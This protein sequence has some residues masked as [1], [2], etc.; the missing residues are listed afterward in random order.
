MKPERLQE[1]EEHIRSRGWLPMEESKQLLA[2]LREAQAELSMAEQSVSQLKEDLKLR[3]ATGSK[4]AF[5]LQEAQERAETAE[6]A[7]FRRGVEAAKE[8]AIDA[9]QGAMM[10]LG[11]PDRVYLNQWGSAAI[12]EIEKDLDAL[13]PLTPTPETVQETES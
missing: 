11:R 10:D 7:G 2:A 1:I 8:A 6:A 12:R 13:L 4:C 9:V 3:T 5:E